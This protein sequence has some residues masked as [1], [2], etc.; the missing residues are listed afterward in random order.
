MASHIHELDHLMCGV[1]DINRCGETFARLG[2]TVGPVTMSGRSGCT[3]RRILF[4]PLDEGQANYLELIQPVK[5]IEECMPLLRRFLAGVKEGAE[6]V[7]ALIMATK[8]A[9]ATH[10]HFTERAKREPGRG[11][12]PDPFFEVD[13]DYQAPTGETFH[14]GFSNAMF[15]RLTPPM[16]VS[17]CQIRGYGFY[18]HEPWRRHANTAQSLIGVIGL[19]DDPTATAAFYEDFW[20]S[21]SKA[22]APGIVACQPGRIAFEI[23]TPAAF[24]DRYP[25]LAP[26]T[27]QK[28]P[29]LLGYRLAVADLAR[30]ESVLAGNGVPRRRIG[31]S[32]VVAPQDAHGQLIEFV[33]RA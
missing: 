9:A 11:F 12:E 15:S 32:L 14:V 10:A 20:E 2:F 3:N 18:L 4:T 23:H 33:A 22:V 17:T 31:A 26:M 8:D 24:A 27:W 25:G 19:A 1:S 13:Y 5:P 28:A 21:G 29:C 16:W 6:G 7:R 30:C